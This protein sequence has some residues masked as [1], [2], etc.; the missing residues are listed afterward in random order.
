MSGDKNYINPI[1]KIYDTDV[2]NKNNYYY[3][4]KFFSIWRRFNDRDCSICCQEIEISD[5][6]DS[7][8]II[9]PCLHYFHKDCLREW[10]RINRSCP[11]CRRQF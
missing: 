1:I 8:I 9:T 6:I 5:F 11:N 4:E 3:E 2:Y 10:F 7:R